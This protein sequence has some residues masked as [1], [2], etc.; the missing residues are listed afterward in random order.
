MVG[1][2]SIGPPTMRQGTRRMYPCPS[3]GVES[4]TIFKFHCGLTTASCCL[5]SPCL[6]LSQ[7]H[8]SLMIPIRLEA[9]FLVKKGYLLAVIGT[10]NQV[11][12]GL[13]QMSTS[14]ELA[15]CTLLLLG[16]VHGP[17][18]PSSRIHNRSYHYCPGQMIANDTITLSLSLTG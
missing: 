17:Y 9:T 8:S 3:A 6:S 15:F 11:Q 7:L 2:S 4:Q 5:P 14:P 13:V 18:P 1:N 16:E 12:E 10:S